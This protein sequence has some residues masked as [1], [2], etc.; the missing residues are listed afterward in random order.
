MIKKRIIKVF[1]GL[2]V[3]VG[4]VLPAAA[5][6]YPNR[7]ITMYTGYGAG[8]VGDVAA[9]IV[10]KVMEKDLGVP[11]I[12]ANRPGAQA[13]LNANLVTRHKPDGYEIGV[14]TFAPL[15][16]VP[17]MLP[18]TYTADDFTFIGGFGRNLY[19]LAVRADSPY[20]NVS[21]LVEAAKKGKSI[22]FGA[23]G[24]PN[25]IA[26]FELGKKTGAQFEQ[27]LYKSGHETVMALIGGQVEAI[28]QGPSEILP[29]VE[30]GRLRL[31]ASV[32]PSRWPIKQDLPTML[33]QGFDVQISSWQG[34]AGPKGMDPTVAASLEKALLDAMKDPE[35]IDQYEKMGFDAVTMTGEEYG[36]AVRKG[37]EDM[38]KAM[39]ELG[40]I[41][42]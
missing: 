7:P 15:A 27:V 17:H 32:S 3:S 40:L 42:N 31:L 9:R 4:V 10:T 14:V 6:D 35:V 23:P 30:A 13:T 33:E 39:K 16:I 29:H 24:A 8:G 22:F 1:G 25:N 38:G 41:P 2:L 12:V 36:K 18:V 20:Q 28:I 34:L 11:I 21:D 5:S 26:M 19:G 37:Y